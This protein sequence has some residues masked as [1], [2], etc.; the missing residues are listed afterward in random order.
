MACNS[1]TPADAERLLALLLFGPFGA[2]ALAFF[3]AVWR[4]WRRND[5]TVPAWR[6]N[7][8][9]LNAYRPPT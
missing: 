4:P 6:Y 5:G 2:G 7:A 1:I 8:C 9:E 3:A